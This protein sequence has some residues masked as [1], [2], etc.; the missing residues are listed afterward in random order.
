MTTIGGWETGDK[1]D[2]SRIFGIMNS[3]RQE[4]EP[5]GIRLMRLMD[6]HLFEIIRKEHRNSNCIHLYGTGEYWAAFE[7]SAY[8]LCRVFPKNET[9]VVT[10]PAYPF[11]VVMVTVSDGDLRTYSRSHIFR[12]DESDYKEFIAP[13]ISPRQYNLWHRNEVQEFL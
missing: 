9:A 7:Q 1:D 12:R 3:Y 6:T 10:H 2:T 8:L 13:E 11:P 4:N 5:C